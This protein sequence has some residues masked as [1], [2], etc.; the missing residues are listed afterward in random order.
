M[1]TIRSNRTQG[2]RNPRLSRAR[3]LSGA[4]PD[5]TAASGP[6]VLVVGSGWKFTSGISY[7]TCR[8]SNALAAV[9]PTRAIL[10]RQ[11]IPTA[12]YPGRSRVGTPVNDLQ[13]DPRVEVLDGID[14]F[15]GRTMI[16]ARAFLDREPPDVIVLQWWTGAVLHSYLALAILARRRGA[17][18]VMEWHEVQD[19]GEARIPGVTRYVRAAMRV[20][21]SKV[22]AHVV[23]SHYDLELLQ[24]AYDLDPRAVT[25][26]P[27]GPYDHVVPAAP[28]PSVV[29]DDCRDKPFNLL[30]FGIIRPYKGLEDLVAA[31]SQLPESVARQMRLTIVGETWEGWSEPLD[32]VQDSPYRDRI[33]VVNRYVTDAE[34]RQFFGDA[35]AVVLPYRRSS[36]SGPLHI[37]MSAGLPLI[38]TAVGGLVE[39]ASPYQGATF[40]PA[41]DPPSLSLALAGLLPLRGRRFADPHSWNA[42]IRA[43]AGIFGRLGLP[44]MTTH[45]EPAGEIRSGTRGEASG[46][47]VAGPLRRSA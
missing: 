29:G 23:H 19:T 33:T 46:Q 10:M 25:F 36:S 3:R 22:D 31:F 6:R 7:Y 26:V 34:A 24:R 4:K 9:T 30:Y 20:L 27:H 28:E 18:V 17:R 44:A 45:S 41:E 35:D 1:S 11:L 32:A 14:W 47:A 37:A 40:V 42:S 5:P 21:A 16:E 13:Y 12:L 39:A 2:Q 43:Y 38:V 8:L 15:W